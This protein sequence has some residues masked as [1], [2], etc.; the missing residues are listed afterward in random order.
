MFKKIDKLVAHSFFG[1]FFLTF[2]V[3]LFILLMVFMSKYFEDLVGKDLGADVFA[4]LFFYFSLTLVPQALPLAIL[5]ASLMAFGNMGEHNELTAIKGC[6]ISLIRIL[7]PVG[8]FAVFMTGVAYIFNDKI[9]PEVNLKA[10]RLLYDV[11]QKEPTLDF[12][13]GSFY[14]GLP[15]W[16]IRIGE[17]IKETDSLKDLIIYDHRS[18]RGNTD[19]IIA[20]KG[21]MVNK[22]GE[23]ILEFHVE[24]GYRYSE[25]LTNGGKDKNAFMRD[26][27]DV[28]TFNFDLSFLQM[29]ETSEEL[30]TQNRYM[31]TVAQLNAEADSLLQD[32]EK[33]EEENAKRARSYFDYTFF[34]DFERER[35]A[36]RAKNEKT[37]EELRKQKAD[38]LNKLFETKDSTLE[39]QN[40]TFNI[41]QSDSNSVLVIDSAKRKAMDSLKLV[42]S[43]ITNKINQTKLDSNTEKIASSTTGVRPN[44]ASS[45]FIKTKMYKGH[46]IEEGLEIPDNITPIPN[47]IDGLDTID[48]KNLSDT[49]TLANQN[50]SD[51]SIELIMDRA[52]TKVRNMRS[53]AKTNGERIK[54]FEYDSRRALLEKN[55]RYSLAVAC[56]IMFL[57]GAPLGAIIKKGGLGVPVLISIVFFILFYIMTI[58]GDKWAREQIVSIFVGSWAA[59]MLLL[60][61]GIV[62]LLQARADSRLFEIDAYIVLF[63]KIK[64]IFIKEKKEDKAKKV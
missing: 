1:L 39:S 51:K 57:I 23:Q 6:G 17:K 28:A 56:F 42:N 44:N 15:G 5:L 63:G 54:R 2:S 34:V 29:N 8:L 12:P 47:A 41:T 18:A 53:F 59:N 27:F 19:L 50:F 7:L 13:E 43:N 62:F 40:D 25:Q 24:N 49:I 60:A 36:Q 55:K 52:L 37:Q 64:R 10:F 58:T 14:N 33:V 30:F 20:D 16:S 22:Q 32:A 26:K 61:F 45:Q 11:R 31:M 9:V 46:R 48:W 4:E 3:V 35:L 21:L 38:S